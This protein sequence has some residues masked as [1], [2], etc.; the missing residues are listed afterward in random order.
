[1]FFEIIFVVNYFD[2]K[3][4][5][6]VLI[7]L[8][9]VFSL[10]VDEWCSDVGCKIVVNMIKGKIFEEIWKFFNIINE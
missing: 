3:F 6:Y 5:L 8:L 2:I 7:G 10:L 4:F 1:M 9:I